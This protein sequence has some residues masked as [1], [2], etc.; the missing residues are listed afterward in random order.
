[1]QASDQGDEAVPAVPNPG[2]FD[3]S[4][5][6]ALLLI[7]SAEKQV[8]LP[9]DDLLAMRLGAKALGALALMDFLLG[10]GSTLRDGV[11][12][13]L[14]LPEIWN[15]FLDGPLHRKTLIS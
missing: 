4:V 2:A 6:T 10:H 11:V 13:H 9:V 12:I 8:H 14:S 3:G 1:V 5:P 7:E 15:L